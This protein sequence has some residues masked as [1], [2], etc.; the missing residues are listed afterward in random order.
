MEGNSIVGRD[1]LIVAAY[2]YY[3]L[4]NRGY[5]P[6]ASEELITAKHGL[7]REERILIKRCIHS[8]SLNR[9]VRSRIL[10]PVE[11]KDKKLCIDGYNQLI[12]VK[13]CLAG[14]PIY[15]CSDGLLRDNELGRLVLDRRDLERLAQVLGEALMELKP[16]IAIIVLD[17]ARPWSRNHSRILAQTLK[18]HTPIRTLVVL[19]KRTDSTLIAYSRSGCIIS[20]SDIVVALHASRIFDLAAYIAARKKCKVTNISPLLD[21]EHKRWCAGP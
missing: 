8:T 7:S 2:E 15:L 3:F 18:Q 14:R 12:T 21:R 16:A 10:A 4:I 20:S 13:A 19:S 9:I 17:S 5:S 1:K 11:V 6:K